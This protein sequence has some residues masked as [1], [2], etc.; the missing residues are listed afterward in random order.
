M[1]RGASRWAALVLIAYAAVLASS[2]LVQAG[3]LGIH[4]ATEHGVVEVA[5]ASLGVGGDHGHEHPHADEHGRHHAP[6]PV[7]GA[8]P[9]EHDGRVHT[10][11]LPLEDERIGALTETSKHHPPIPP[12]PV[13]PAARWANPTTP[14]RRSPARIA[15]LVEPPPPRRSV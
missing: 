7:E 15:A 8:Q 4:L 5:E 14:V 6:R 13:A 2:R 3:L 11:E 10:H 9:H 12:V 1:R